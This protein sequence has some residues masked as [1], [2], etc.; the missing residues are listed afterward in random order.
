[1]KGCKTGGAAGGDIELW[2][3]QYHQRAIGHTSETDLDIEIH[4]K[5][6][7]V[8]E[9][10]VK[11]HKESPGLTDVCL[12]QDYPHI[13]WS[14]IY[15]H[16]PSKFGKEGTDVAENGFVAD[17]MKDL[18]KDLNWEH[19]TRGGRL[20]GIDMTLSETQ[21]NRDYLEVST[22]VNILNL[23]KLL[24]MQSILAKRIALT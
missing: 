4:K 16:I 21:I 24:I 13:F 15:H 22:I 18:C 12:A 14:L 17:M 9:C 6:T 8:K 1:M 23:Y 7:F 11:C 10:L 3:V 20:L 19:M 5:P 2:T